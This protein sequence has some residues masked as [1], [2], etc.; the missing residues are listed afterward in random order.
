MTLTSSYRRNSL[1][2]HHCDERSISSGSNHSAILKGDDECLL[3]KFISNDD[4]DTLI[5]EASNRSLSVLKGLNFF[6]STT[7]RIQQTREYDVSCNSLYDEVLEEGSERSNT[8]STSA[9]CSNA[10][11][12]GKS[13]D[14]QIWKIESEKIEHER[15]TKICREFGLTKVNGKAT[16]TTTTTKD[17]SSVSKVSSEACAGPSSSCVHNVN[18][19][20][21]DYS[22]CK[23]LPRSNNDSLKTLLFTSGSKKQNDSFM[24]LRQLMEE[25]KSSTTTTCSSHNNDNKKKKRHDRKKSDRKGV[26]HKSCPKFGYENDN[27]SKS[28]MNNTTTPQRIVITRARSVDS[29]FN[30]GFDLSLMDDDSIHT[31]TS[32]TSQ[33][34]CITFD[35]IAET[36]QRKPSVQK[37]ER[38]HD[39]FGAGTCCG[40]GSNSS[41]G[42]DAPPRVPRRD[43]SPIQRMQ[44][45]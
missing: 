24:K 14:H 32:C 36:K 33:L 11:N 43:R 3:E 5:F 31:V 6:N 37:N 29:C 30:Y 40:H 41:S 23:M 4:S 34:S 13:C 27:N 17:S 42:I 44:C 19:K 45:Y 39:P 1:H 8:T 12:T 22:S 7:T 26:M 18:L 15:T 2:H 28:S 25:T 10:S 16:T 9:T 21:Q 38:L 35:D 20:N